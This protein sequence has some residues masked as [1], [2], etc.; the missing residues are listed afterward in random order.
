MFHDDKHNGGDWFIKTIYL[1]GPRH[2]V[3]ID[4]REIE[5]LFGCK[6]NG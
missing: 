4:K 3:E 6:M 5:K 1:D 2:D